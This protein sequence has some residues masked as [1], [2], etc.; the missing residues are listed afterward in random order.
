MTVG[1]PPLMRMEDTNTS[2]PSEVE[3]WLITRDGIGEGKKNIVRVAH[4]F[5]AYYAVVLEEL[6]HLSNTPQRDFL[7][8]QDSADPTKFLYTMFPKMTAVPDRA[9]A[10][11][12]IE[13]TLD[14]IDAK[15]PP[16]LQVPA[17]LNFPPGLQEMYVF[18][19]IRLAIIRVSS[20][21]CRWGLQAITVLRRTICEA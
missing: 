13:R 2:L 19:P 15:L 20:S 3:D 4:N 12:R 8:S 6:L 17:D 7:T 18:Q 1:R 9:A 16:V 14:H 11:D 10:L 21:A 5:V